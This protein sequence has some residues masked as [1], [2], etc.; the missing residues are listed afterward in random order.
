MGVVLALNVKPYSEDHAIKNVIFAL[1]FSQTLPSEFLEVVRDGEVGAALKA[2]LPRV[3]EQKALVFNFSNVG[4]GLPIPAKIGGAGGA[5][6]A[7]SGLNYDKVK[8]NGES[9]WAVSVNQNLILVTCGNYSRWNGIWPTVKKLLSGLLSEVLKTTSIGVVGLQY[10]D[11]F[12]SLGSKEDFSLKCLFV[13]GSIYLPSHFVDCQGQCHSHNGYY[14]RVEN[15][16]TGNILNNI[17]VSVTEQSA[18]MIVSIVGSHRYTPATPI[19]GATVEALL[20]DEGMI[21]GIWAT[22]HKVNK[23]IIGD[24]LTAEVKEAI[25]FAGTVPANQG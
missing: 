5:Q 20:S 14:E 9:E 12:S 15:P 6:Q 8:P 3:I 11:E 17:N 19:A 16:V 24:V 18:S 2:D 10:T 4:A 13:D 7:L 25:N 22:L 1:E 23:N 21:T